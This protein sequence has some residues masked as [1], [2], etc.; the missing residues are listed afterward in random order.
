MDEVS[1]PSLNFPYELNRQVGPMLK[2]AG[3]TVDG[4]TSS[5]YPPLLQSAARY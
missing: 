3:A 1:V 5:V 2:Y 4:V